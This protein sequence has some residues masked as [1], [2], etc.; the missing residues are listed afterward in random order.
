MRL[1]VRRYITN[2]QRTAERQR[3]VTE[4]DCNEIKQDISALRYELIELLGRDKTMTGAN[5]TVGRKGRQ[6]ER[7]LMKG[8]DFNFLFMEP[9][10]SFDDDVY[11]FE[12][13]DCSNQ[14]ISKSK[15]SR[16]RFVRLARGLAGKRSRGNNRW[17]QLIEATRSKVMPFSRSSESVNSE[18]CG[19]NS[20]SSTVPST[21]YRSP[22]PG[23]L[24]TGKRTHSSRIMN[25]NRNFSLSL[26]LAQS[27][28]ANVRRNMFAKKI[29]SFLKEESLTAENDEEPEI[30]T[31]PPIKSEEVNQQR[32]EPTSQVISVTHNT[33]RKE[34]I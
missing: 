1:L 29:T 14:Q 15:S 7:R 3:G 17:K 4:D 2:E 6:R 13:L 5:A 34:W 27:F 9:T 11:D 23:N 26:S 28:D 18:P 25:S 32:T 22:R 24:P 8:F 30:Q 12:D 21:M 19:D 16:S 20:K 10:A 33:N 31:K